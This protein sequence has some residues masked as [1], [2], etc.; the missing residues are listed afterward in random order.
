MSFSFSWVLLITMTVAAVVDVCVFV[1][2]LI[3]PVS[4]EIG[5]P[6]SPFH[7]APSSNISEHINAGK[8]YFDGE[9]KNTL[10]AYIRFFSNELEIARSIFL[11]CWFFRLYLMPFS[12]KSIP[13][14]IFWRQRFLPA[15]GFPASHPDKRKENRG[16]R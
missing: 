1:D 15:S 8:A 13:E 2:S 3:M 11:V 7:L 4:N 5:A 6:V 16:W 9:T 12:T 10:N 14:L